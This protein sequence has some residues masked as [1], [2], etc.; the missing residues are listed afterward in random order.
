MAECVEM[1]SLR[2]LEQSICRN[3]TFSKQFANLKKDG[4]EWRRSGRPDLV[5]IH[6]FIQQHRMVSVG[7]DHDTASFAVNR[8]AAGGEAL[9]ANA[10]A[11]LR[12]MISADRTAATAIWCGYGKLN[13]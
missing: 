7:T 6:D 9:E 8:C 12:P 13:C 1:A 11:K 2:S 5:N 3:R 10:I 4:R